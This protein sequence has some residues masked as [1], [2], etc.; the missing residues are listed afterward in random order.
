MIGSISRSP[1]SIGYSS[2]KWCPAAKNP[3][4]LYLLD[5]KGETH[6]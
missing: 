3:E 5:I 2:L 1:G 6:L 4:E